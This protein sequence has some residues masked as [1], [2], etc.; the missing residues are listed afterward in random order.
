MNED[1]PFWRSGSVLFALATLVGIVVT[2]AVLR[3]LG[4]KAQDFTLFLGRFHPLVVHLPI[5]FVLLVGAA[6]AAT[7][8]PKLRA[9]LDPAIALALPLLVLATLVAFVLG[10][11]LARSGDF[12]PGAL[13]V[14]RRFELFAAV[15][16]CLCPLAWEYQEQSDSGRA[17]WVYRA[18][19]GVALGVLS[20]GAHFG[21]TL[22]R[23]DSYLT[24]YAPEPFK[25]LLGGAPAP[26]PSAS[27]VKPPAREPRLFADV[28]EPILSARCVGCH[29][30]EKVKGGLR[31][32]S[33]AALTKGGEDGSVVTPGNP[34]D[35]PLLSRVLLPADDDDHMPPEGK[36]GLTPAE[37]AAVRFWIERGAN[38]T[39]LVRDLLVPADARSL[40]EGALSATPAPKTPTAVTHEGD[41]PSPSSSAGSAPPVPSASPT[42]APAPAVPRAPSSAST[43]GTS[44][45]PEPAPSSPAPAAARG[46]GA[47]QIFNDKCVKCHGPLKQKGKLRLDSVDS[48]LRGG[49]SGAAVVAGDPDASALVRRMNLGL[50]DDQHMP[51]AKEPQPS[52][53]DKA[54]VAAW[55]HALGASRVAGAG[56]S[57]TSNAVARGISASAGLSREATPPGAPE[58]APAH[59]DAPPATPEPTPADLLAGLP[60]HLALY[61]SEVAPLLHARCAKCHGGKTPAGGLVVDDYSALLKGGDTGPAITPGKPEQSLLVHRIGLPPEDDDHMPPSDEQQLS[62][63]EIALIGAWVEHGASASAET[64]LAE[65]SR[66]AVEAVA[67][68]PPARAASDVG[69]ASPPPRSGGCGAC[70]FSKPKGA[71]ENAA[72][73]LALL[74]GLSI[75]RRRTRGSS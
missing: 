5:G 49:K 70:T 48:I 19:L 6:E 42:S 29:G 8:S 62:S 59:A 50:D 32:D 12:A 10:H 28:I 34:S 11:L 46:S 44:A 43:A 67:A 21:G 1:R 57:A 25:R 26:T 23:G 16:I 3:H 18:L 72:L 75:W 13:S 15:G 38:D 17:R 39:L 58:A 24:R 55:I 69:Q 27:A 66:P 4:G 36:P 54:A 47:L 65:L 14:H 73:G 7:L 40:L 53:A 71:A 45:A 30:E 74:L 9:R 52:G 20:I 64:A 41:Q 22:T 56:V 68:H 2:D 31:L 37:I 33:L 63:N 35:S 61:P 51:P 60:S